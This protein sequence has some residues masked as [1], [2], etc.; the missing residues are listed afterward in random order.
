MCFFFSICLFYEE[1][2]LLKPH[3][4]FNHWD[5]KPRLLLLSPSHFHDRA[6]PTSP[7]LAHISWLVCEP[8]RGDWDF[9]GGKKSQWK[10]LIHEGGMKRWQRHSANFPNACYRCDSG[11]GGKAWH[12]FCCSVQHRAN[13]CA[14]DD[15]FLQDGWKAENEICMQKQ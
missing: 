7:S 5:I 14:R 11:L 15:S 3:L 9:R 13:V 12:K 2:N 4:L 10:L 8:Q 1:S 6:S